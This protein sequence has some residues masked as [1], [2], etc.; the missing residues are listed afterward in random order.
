MRRP[1][2]GQLDTA[3]SRER[4]HSG[5]SMTAM[6]KFFIHKCTL[7][8]MLKIFYVRIR[9]ARESWCRKAV[10]LTCPGCSQAVWYLACWHSSLT[11]SYLGK[12]LDCWIFLLDSSFLR[13]NFL[14]QKGK[15]FFCEKGSEMTCA[16]T[17]LFFFLPCH[18]TPHSPGSKKLVSRVKPQEPHISR[19]L[20]KKLPAGNYEDE[21]SGEE[22][23]F[24]P[25]SFISKLWAE[26][27][28]FPGS[29]FFSC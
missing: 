14:W 26:T 24:P 13:S 6:E 1:S 25:K 15:S 28:S 19:V 12:W 2:L 11:L 20:C 4:C 29:K 5:H 21:R 16:E 17:C 3:Q 23:S 8:D 9:E 10:S 22:E 7:F 27:F 18:M